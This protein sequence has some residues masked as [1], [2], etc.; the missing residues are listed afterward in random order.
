MELPFQDISFDLLLV[1]ASAHHYPD[2]GEFLREAHRVAKAVC[3]LA[4]PATLGPAQWIL[5]R[6]RRSTEY[7]G[8]DTH[9]LNEGQVRHQVEALGMPISLGGVLRENSAQS[10]Y[11]LD[12]TPFSLRIYLSESPARTPVRAGD[13]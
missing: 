13:R 12:S 8:V 4:E 11:R 7:G 2:M 9:R 10:F 6:L 5:R 3:L 1:Y